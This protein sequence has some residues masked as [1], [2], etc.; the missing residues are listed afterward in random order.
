MRSHLYRSRSQQ[1]AKSLRQ[2]MTPQER[3]LW[4]DFLRLAPARF[5]RQRPIGRY[6]VDFVCVSAKLM[7]ELDG[8][9][10]CEPEALVWDEERTKELESMGYRVLRISN[11]D[12]SQHFREVCEKILQAVEDAGVE[13]RSY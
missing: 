6:I 10:H 13:G 1:N 2:N 7:V 9:Q 4:Y 11:L 8:S 12:V 3:H 5:Q